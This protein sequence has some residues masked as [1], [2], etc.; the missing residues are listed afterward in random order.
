MNAIARLPPPYK[1][2]PQFVRKFRFSNTANVSP[3]TYLITRFSAFTTYGFSNSSI[4]ATSAFGS[5]KITRVQIWTTAFNSVSSG[6]ANIVFSN[7]TWLSETAPNVEISSAGNQNNPAY[8]SSR[9]PDNSLAGFW[10]SKVN[11]GTAGP[12]TSANLFTIN[13]PANTQI[14]VD[15]E[16]MYVPCSHGEE[17]TF[18]PAGATAGT[19]TY[20]AL[21]NAGLLLPVGNIA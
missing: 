2:D 16:V 8:V 14:V 20:Q 18:N 10:T 6:S 17:V 7:L 13:I 12:T 5:L 21:D 19:F 15:I 9:P 1:A 11:V 3:T 4:L